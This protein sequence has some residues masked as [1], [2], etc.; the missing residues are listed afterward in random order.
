MTHN[1]KFGHSLNAIV[2]FFCINSYLIIVFGTGTFS[3]SIFEDQGAV[4]ITTIFLLFLAQSFVLLEASSSKNKKHTIDWLL[5]AFILQI[6]LMREAD[7]H[8][9]FT[10]I[11]VTKLK[12][13]KDPDSPLLGKIIAGTF[14][15]SF[16]LF[17][18]YL[19]VKYFKQLLSSFLRMKPWAISSA[20]WFCLLSLS[21]ILDKSRLNSSEDL[22]IK[23]IEEMFE[24]SAAIYLLT[25]LFLWRNHRLTVSD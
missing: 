6:Y 22:R 7:F 18:V 4:S 12:F 13:Y 14:L 19:G 11:N 15:V 5:L 23:N 10:E 25:A 3:M 21:Q 16:L 2:M 17:S 24:L 8:R 20:L 1:E 9:V